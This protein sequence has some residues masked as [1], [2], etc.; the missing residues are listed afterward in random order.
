MKV[1][2]TL[3]VIVA[4]LIVLVRPDLVPAPLRVWESEAS[5][6]TAGPDTTLA[7]VP[8]PTPPATGGTQAQGA[9]A[10]APSNGTGTGAATFKSL[11]TS[12][13]GLLIAQLGGGEA[14]KATRMSLVALPSFGGQST[15]KFNQNV[16]SDMRKALNE[17]TKFSQLRHN[18]WPEGHSMEIGFEDK[19][20][21]K[22]GPSAAVACALLLE[23]AITGK[24]WDPAF[25]VTGDMNADGSVQP[26]GGVAAKIR[27]A[28]KGSCKIVG[29]PVKNEK[30]VADILVTDGPAPLVA[31]TI[32]SLTKFDDALLL[33]DPERP[34]A[35]QTALAGFD[36]MRTVMLRNPQQLVPLLRNPHA[37]QRL[38]ALYTAAP[39]C[40]SAKYLLLYLQGNAP[41][42]LS[43]GGS[44]EAAQTSAQGII[45][46][47]NRDIDG[48]S[49]LTGDELGGSLNK[50][51]RLRPSLDQR[52]W[53]Y[54]DSLM[55]FAEVIRTSMSN[56]PT[57]GSAR[58]NDMVARARSAAGGA[59]SA[60]EKLINDPQVREE[61][62]L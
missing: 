15:L 53:P 49:R 39:N 11:Q 20:V 30:S 31:I 13:N 42:S 46:A 9:A 59:K 22:D 21:D 17:V 55:T 32:F 52:V 50:L 26:I 44:I 8:A 4:L 34:A 19:Y 12:V 23:G 61:L 10:P 18:G 41:R 3:A 60:Y 5:D 24:K 45:T 37:L 51:R 27:G 47:I 43:I 1:G 25:A 2:I 14:G 40:L 16:G 38:Q 56:P 35:L 62:D 58:F 29:L 33:A 6:G 7:V 54:V 28:T 57:R 48:I 36:G